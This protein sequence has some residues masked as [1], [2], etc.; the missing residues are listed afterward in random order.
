MR[1]LREPFG[2]VVKFWVRATLSYNWHSGVVRLGKEACGMGDRFTPGAD[3]LP[4][5]YEWFGWA[6]ARKLR[7]EPNRSAD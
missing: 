5:I 1:V 4:P 3:R 7:C 6:K 2:A